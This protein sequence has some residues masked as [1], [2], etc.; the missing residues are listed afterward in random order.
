MV[1]MAVI[2]AVAAALFFAVAMAGGAAVIYVSS[3]SKRWQ[4]MANAMAGGV[5]IGVAFMHMLGDNIAT[6]DLWGHSLKVSLGGD[7]DDVP[8]PL[9]L[10]FA[11]C[12][13]YLIFGLEVLLGGHPEHDHDHGTKQPSQDL[14]SDSSASSSSVKPEDLQGKTDVTGWA[15]LIGVSTHSL[16]EGLATGA[17]RDPDTLGILVLAVVM[18]KGFAAFAVAASL[19]DIRQSKGKATW[20]ALVVLFAVTGPFGII[21]GSIFRASLD[22]QAGAVLQ[23]TAAGTLL[24]IAVTDMVMPAF[25]DRSV[26]RK[27]KLFACFMGCF[28]MSSLAIWA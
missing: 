17:A 14:E 11:A 28:A 4:Q 2:D 24:A 15:T 22:E 7:P 1:S 3:L 13:F 8:F 9:G 6:L 21:V 25:E 26:W 23:C 20:W 16:L 10:A 19:Q 12:G 18:H 5:L 27:R